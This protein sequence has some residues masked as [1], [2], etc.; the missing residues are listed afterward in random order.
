VTEVLTVVELVLVVAGVSALARRVGLPTPIALVLVG[1]ALSYVPGVPDIRLDPEIV[2]VLVLPPLLYAAAFNTPFRAFRANLVPIGLLSVG[3]VL[4]TAVV[5]GLV[6]YAVV[7]GLPLA[8]ALALGAIV[9]PPDAVAATAVAR[10][11]GLPDR[12]VTVLEGESL[13]NDATALV[14][15]RVAVAAVVSGS[16]SLSGAAGAFLLA[17]VGGAA[18]GF[19]VSWLMTQLRRRT[20]DPLIENVL[21]LVTPFLA[22]LP[23]EEMHASGVLAVVIAGLHSGHTAPTVMTPAARLQSQAIWEV[24]EFLLQGVVFTLIGLQ[25]R[26]IV[27]AVDADAGTVASA[28]AAVTAAVVVSRFAWVFPTTYLRRLPRRVRARDPFP[29]WQWPFVISWAGM[30]GVVSLA[31][32]FALPLTTDTGPFP[33]RALLVLLSF[34]VIAVTLVLQGLTLPMVIRWLRLPRPDPAELNLQEAAAQHAAG[35]AAVGRLEELLARADAP[36][37]G[38]EQRL[39]DMVE[40]RQLFAWERLGAGSNRET[41]SAAYRRLRKA[42]LRAERDVLLQMRNDGRID[43]T[44]LRRVQRD[45]DLEE[46]L[47]DR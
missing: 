19:A 38:V 36:P 1:V 40:K 47:L 13:L 32:A 34:V 8:A 41:P 24:I 6:A 39:R 7:P 23:A 2:L 18:V 12:V 10:R 4:F 27:A 28:A 30:R 20:T 15:Y 21:A 44:V 33:Q 11:V 42:M 43:E 22:Y 37:A 17:S 29:P 46:A 9:A 5:V 14:A 25:L 31:A 45:L 3:L 16:V 35:S 26:D